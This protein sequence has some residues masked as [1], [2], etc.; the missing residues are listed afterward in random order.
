[1]TLERIESAELASQSTGGVD[2]QRVPASGALAQSNPSVLLITPNSA[3]VPGI[4]RVTLRGAGGGALA[5]LNSRT[6][7]S[8]I[9]FD[10]TVEPAQ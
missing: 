4:Y 9:S 6:L 5:D 2:A 10:F 1:V 7:G 3:L 8:D